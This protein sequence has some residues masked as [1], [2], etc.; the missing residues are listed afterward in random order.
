MAGGVSLVK[1]GDSIVLMVEVEPTAYMLALPKDQAARLA[2]KI[3][4][5]CD[6]EDGSDDEMDVDPLARMLRGLK[7]E[8]EQ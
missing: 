4:E 8:G 7:P 6:G 5:H 3:L 2:R 1:V